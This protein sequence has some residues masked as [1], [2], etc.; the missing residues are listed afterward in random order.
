MRGCNTLREEGKIYTTAEFER[1]PVC[2]SCIF[3]NMYYLTSLSIA[4]TITDR[5]LRLYTGFINA[6]LRSLHRSFN[7]EIDVFY[8]ALRPALTMEY[9]HY[10]ANGVSD[11]V[12]TCA[13]VSLQIFGYFS[14]QKYTQENPLVSTL[15]N[16]DW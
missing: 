2:N 15:D 8:F 1:K 5:S 12:Q 3:L 11:L 16:M 14:H 10:I 6:I 9:G 13:R 4:K 7:V